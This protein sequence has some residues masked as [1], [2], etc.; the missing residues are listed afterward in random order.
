M[1]GYF[2]DFKLFQSNLNKKK[3]KSSPFLKVDIYM[4]IDIKMNFIYFYS[5]FDLPPEVSWLV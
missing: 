5:P 1:N 3:Q 2:F 4:I